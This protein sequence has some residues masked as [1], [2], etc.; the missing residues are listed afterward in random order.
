MPNSSLQIS[1]LTSVHDLS[2]WV[3]GL[4]TFQGSTGRPECWCTPPPYNNL[5]L[6]YTNFGSRAAFLTCISF[7]APPLLSPSLVTTTEG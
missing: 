3:V 1:F 6:P 5:L 4:L 2:M 7:I